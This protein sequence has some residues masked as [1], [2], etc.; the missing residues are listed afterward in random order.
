MMK[1]QVA[2]SDSLK[3]IILKSITGLENGSDEVIFE[4]ETGTIY[5]MFHNQE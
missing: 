5:R 1:K 4:T 2:F 3:G